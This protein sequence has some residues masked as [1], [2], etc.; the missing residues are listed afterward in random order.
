[1]TLGCGGF[2]AL[3]DSSRLLVKLA[4]SDI[5]QDPGLLAGAFETAQGGVKR[6]VLTY[7]ND[8]HVE[9]HLPFYIKKIMIKI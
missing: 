5:G 7:S 4:G 8:W 6:L 1:V 3:T 2:G 9:N